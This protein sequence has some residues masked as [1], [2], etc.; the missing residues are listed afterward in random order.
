MIELDLWFQ[1]YLAEIDPPKGYS[2]KVLWYACKRN[3]TKEEFFDNMVYN[4][5]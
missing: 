4:P 1:L 3:M 5:F 2:S